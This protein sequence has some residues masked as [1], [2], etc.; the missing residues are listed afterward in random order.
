MWQPVQS[1][2]MPNI[3]FVVKSRKSMYKTCAPCTSSPN[4]GWKR[5]YEQFY[6]RENQV[7]FSEQWV[8]VEGNQSFV[9]CGTKVLGQVGSRS[10][11][12]TGACL[13]SDRRYLKVM[14]VRGN[15]TIYGFSKSIYFNRCL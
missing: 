9:G 13:P 11:L 15:S 1:L 2:E 4:D 8:K 7:L 10:L 3:P 12:G 6:N 5:Q 14:R